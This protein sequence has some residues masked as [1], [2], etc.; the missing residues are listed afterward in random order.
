MRTNRPTN[1]AEVIRL[2]DDE[3]MAWVFDGRWERA[4][5]RVTEMFGNNVVKA[6]AWFMIPLELY[7]VMYRAPIE[8]LYSTDA[9]DEETFHNIVNEQKLSFSQIRV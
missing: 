9:D 5:P 2:L 8:Y 1:R 7:G 4:W 3:N 6:L